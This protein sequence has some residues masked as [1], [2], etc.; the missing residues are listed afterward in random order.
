M[1]NRYNDRPHSS[2][3]GGKFSDLNEL[4]YTEFLRYYYSVSKAQDGND[5]QPGVLK[6]EISED[7]LTDVNSYP[8]IIP[9]MPSKDKLKCWKVPFVM[10]FYVPM[11]TVTLRKLIY[12][13]L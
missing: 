4:C 6:D 5:N 13:V 1:V 2:F 11:G 3:A 7:N 12:Q 10:K 9:L 8:K